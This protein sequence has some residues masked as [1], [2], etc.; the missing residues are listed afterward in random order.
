MP[1][2][3][4]DAP[5]AL[6][7]PAAREAVRTALSA[8]VRRSQQGDVTLG[9]TASSDVA[10]IEVPVLVE[11][12]ADAAHADGDLTLRIVARSMEALFPAFDGRV[13]VEPTDSADSRIRLIGDYR[14]PLGVLGAVTNAT[15]LDGIAREGL[16]KFVDDLARDALGLVRAETEERLREV[17]RGVP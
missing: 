1:Q 17:R 3:E 7:A 12:D 2:I 13:A 5:V 14:V 4:V 10:R 16:Q 8:T 15:A 6:A 9:A 11:S